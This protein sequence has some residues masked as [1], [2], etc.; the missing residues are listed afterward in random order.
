MPPGRRE[1]FAARVLAGA[2][3][4]LHQHL[5]GGV[6]STIAGDTSVTFLALASARISFD[7]WRGDQRF[8]RENLGD[9]GA[10]G[11]LAERLDETA[12]RIVRECDQLRARA[13]RAIAFS[14]STTHG[15]G[16]DHS[17]RLRRGV[18]DVERELGEVRLAAVVF[19]EKYRLQFGAI[20]PAL[21]PTSAS[22][23]KVSSTC[24]TPMLVMPMEPNRLTAFSA[25][26]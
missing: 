1:P 10:T 12:G 11:V 25:S 5:G 7:Q 15:S 2:A 8:V 21:I 23:P 3:Q 20:K 17:S 14:A 22:A 9:D 13:S 24:S 4:A 19:A 18:T 16:A 26:R 6:T